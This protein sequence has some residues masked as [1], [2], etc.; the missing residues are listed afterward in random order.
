MAFSLSVKRLAGGLIMG[1]LCALVSMSIPASEKRSLTDK[2]DGAR[3]Q[4]RATEQ[5]QLQKARDAA[6]E[7]Q[8]R[9]TKVLKRLQP[10][11]WES[12]QVE[13]AQRQF[14]ERESREDKYLREAKE[15][16]SKERKIPKP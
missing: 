2:A 1:L 8:S 15:A 12:E 11:D 4:S 3:K 14:N 9:A 5:E 7:T 16:A 10:A 6:D 13:K